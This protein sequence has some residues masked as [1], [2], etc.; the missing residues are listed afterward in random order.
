VVSV[1][2][3]CRNLVQSS[4][5]ACAAQPP[6]VLSE[7]GDFVVIGGEAEISWLCA[8]VWFLVYSDEG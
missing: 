4:D 3:Y 5:G 6:L 8:H 1:V 2:N 7:D